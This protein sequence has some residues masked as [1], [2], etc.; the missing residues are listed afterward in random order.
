VASSLSAPWVTG[1]DIMQRRAFATSDSMFVSFKTDAGF[2]LLERASDG[3]LVGPIAVPGTPIL[4]R[5]GTSTNLDS[6]EFNGGAL[7]RWRWDAAARQWNRGDRIATG[8]ASAEELT[9]NEKQVM[10]LVGASRTLT[11]WTFGINPAVNPTVAQWHNFPTPAQLASAPA[12]RDTQAGFVNLSSTIFGVFYARANG[13]IGLYR[14]FDLT[15][16]FGN[17]FVGDRNW[18]STVASNGFDWLSRGDP[19]IGVRAENGQI[20]LS[21]IDYS[22]MASSGPSTTLAGPTRPGPGPY[23]NS[24]NADLACEAAYPRLAMVDDR[25]FITWQERCAPETRWRVVLR[26]MR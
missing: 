20:I 8:L 3:G 21:T 23:P 16:Q 24:L 7:D 4:S 15:N 18:G 5:T 17:P 14:L 9:G 13:S 1:G 6:L 10:A 11:V 22:A 25:L 12:M 19:T 26:V 2:A